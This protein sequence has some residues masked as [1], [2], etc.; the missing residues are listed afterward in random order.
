MLI[1]RNTRLLSDYLDPELRGSVPLIQLTHGLINRLVMV[2]DIVLTLIVALIA[3]R[4]MFNPPLLNGVQAFATAVLFVTVMV[5]TL[6]Q[7]QCYRLERLVRPWMSSRDLLQAGIPAAASSALL[8]WIFLPDRMAHPGWLLGW[9]G[10]VLLGL[11]GSRQIQRAFCRMVERRSLLRRRVAVIGTSQAAESLVVHMRDPSSRHQYEVV[12][13]FD[14]QELPRQTMV[15]G[16]PVSGSVADLVQ[17]AQH[18]AV[19]MIAIALPWERSMAIF[20]LIEQV[21]WISADVVV[22]FEKSGFRPQIAKLSEVCGAPVLQVMFRPFKGTQGLLKIVQDYVI[23]ALALLLTAPIMLIAALLIRLDG[24]GPVFFRQTRVGFNG[25]AFKIFKFRTMTVDP[26]DDGSVGTDKF[27]PRITRIGAFLRRS[28][29]DELP[30]LIN[31]IR[32]EMSIVGPRPHVPGMLVGDE[33]YTTSVRRYAARHR[34]KPGI[35]GWA[36]INGMRGGIHS[37]AKAER[38]VELDLYYI[39]NWS[40][41]LDLRI[42]FRTILIGMAGRDVF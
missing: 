41:Q 38:G 29:I 21:Q 10:W 22:P 37:V 13:I 12:G 32:G 14:D 25:R 27:N 40:F 2:S 33:T 6:R 17:F 31:V 34:I 15:A 39:T 19:D 30:Q 23:G 4:P 35:T 7:N 9:G 5:L 36:Q 11:L 26:D 28:S 1:S 8:L 16:L 3:R 20:Q 42:I 18:S 24:P